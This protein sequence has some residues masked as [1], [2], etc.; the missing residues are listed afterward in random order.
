MSLE[1]GNVKALL[2]KPVEREK[3]C[4]LAESLKPATKRDLNFQ[5]MIRVVNIRVVLYSRATMFETR[6]QI[7]PCSPNSAVAQLVWRQQS[8]LTLLKH[9]PAFRRPKLMQF[10]RTFRPPLL[11]CPRGCLC[12]GTAGQS[13]GPRSFGSL[14]FR[15]SWHSTGT[16]PD[17]GGIWEN[18]LN[19][20]IGKEGWKQIL[21]D[22]W[23]II[24]YHA[25]Y[26]CML[27]VYV[28]DFKLACPTENMEKAWASIRRAVNIGDPETYDRYFA[29]QHVEFNNVTLP[30][31]AH[32]FAHVFD[33]QAAAAARTQHRTNGFWQH[34]P[35]NKTWT[36]YHLQPRKK[37]FEP[38]DEG[39]KFAKSLHS[40][41]VTM[42][43][44]MLNSQVSSSQ[45][46]HV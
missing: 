44:K 40:E 43:D 4:T 30:R 9:S 5:L 8:C 27:V 17:S 32:P 39:V 11:V 28:D 36:R 46:A 12:H 41:R 6:I 21:P 13:T 22:V 18:H 37:F 33:S 35:I 1:S 14:W 25:E 3:R 26:N 19:P 10:R 23:Q 42:F 15:L 34:D 38:G 16:H 7:T 45:H 24:F 31:K 29:C 2:K 20:R